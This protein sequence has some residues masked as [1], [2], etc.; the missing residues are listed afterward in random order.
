[1]L[2]WLTTLLASFSSLFTAGADR[3]NIALPLNTAIIA[4]Q[5]TYHAPVVADLE[6]FP[7]ANKATEG[8]VKETIATPAVVAPIV[9][10]TPPAPA[11]IAPLAPVVPPQEVYLVNPEPI[12]DWYV[13]VT[14]RGDSMGDG[15]SRTL[16]EMTFDREF[17]RIEVLAYWAPGGAAKPLI[18]KDYFK[19][20]AYE[21]E[22]DKLIYTMTSGNDDALHKL[23]AFKKPGTYY[24]KTYLKDPS[25]YEITFTFGGK[26][27]H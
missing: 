13:P 22:T 26:A 3:P 8:T 11:P 25:Q 7:W 20:E 23:Q 27:V 4:Y 18:E 19:L 24:F 2:K 15:A 6:N 12:V 1:M 5:E 17:W 21:K 9:A 10:P 14:F 16:P